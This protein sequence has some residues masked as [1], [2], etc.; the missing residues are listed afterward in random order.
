MTDPHILS[1]S[2]TDYF[3]CTNYIYIYIYIYILGGGGGGL[4]SIWNQDAFF[5]VVFFWN[6]KLSVVSFVL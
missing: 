4:E 1:D 5:C 3:W 2:V 6:F